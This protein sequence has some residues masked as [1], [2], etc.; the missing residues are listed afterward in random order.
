MENKF[1]WHSQLGFKRTAEIPNA[2]GTHMILNTRY[3]SANFLLFES[4]QTWGC[5][6]S[7]VPAIRDFNDFLN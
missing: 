2:Q 5:A 3:A 1:I 6:L 4:L 7:K